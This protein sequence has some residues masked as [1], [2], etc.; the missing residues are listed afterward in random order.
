ME[1]EEGRGIHF[2]YILFL[3]LSSFLSPSSDDSYN[4]NTI[5]YTSSHLFRPERSEDAS[6]FDMQISRSKKE[7]EDGWLGPHF[8]ILLPCRPSVCPV[9]QPLSCGNET[10]RTKGKV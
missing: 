4:A 10:E 5:F 9:Y 7:E 1:M 2:I 6:R 8:T 3:S